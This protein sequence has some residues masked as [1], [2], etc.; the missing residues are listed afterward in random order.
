MNILRSGK[1][2]LYRKLFLQAFADRL[3]ISTCQVPV[4]LLPDGICLRLLCQE[5]FEGDTVFR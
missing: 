1:Y 2:L 3:H 4:H 5:F